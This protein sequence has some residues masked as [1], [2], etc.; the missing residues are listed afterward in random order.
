MKG[1]LTLYIDE[2]KS[3]QGAQKDDFFDQTQI[4]NLQ[5]Q[6]DWNKTHLA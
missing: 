6:K 3:Q 4:I 1:I 2:K 5:Y